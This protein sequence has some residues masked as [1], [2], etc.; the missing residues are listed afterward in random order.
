M[1]YG[2]A[3]HDTDKWLDEVQDNL[4]KQIAESAFR[5]VLHGV[6]GMPAQKPGQCPWCGHIRKPSLKTKVR[7]LWNQIL[8]RLRNR[9]EAA[10]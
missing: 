4:R 9:N 3:M 7:R 2:K 10:E 6:L 1:K 5:A 8:Y